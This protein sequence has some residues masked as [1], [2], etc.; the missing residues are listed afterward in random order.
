MK[1]EP[2]AIEVERKFV[3][4]GIKDLQALVQEEGGKL[5][6][7]KHFSDAYFDSDDCVLARQDVWLRRRDSAWELKV[8]VGDAEHRS[9]G[10]RSVFREIE[11]AEAVARALLTLHANGYLPHREIGPALEN[12]DLNLEQLLAEMRLKP[13]AEFQT[14]RSRLRLGRCGIDVDTASFG[15]AVL[16]LEIMCQDP[17]EVPEAEAE[18]ERVAQRLGLQPLGAYGGKL[19][20]YIRK[21][22]PNVLAHL[23]DARILKP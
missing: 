11:G 19:E 21:Y 15:H 3:V 12:H 2:R 7:E 5:L 14:M 20:T 1:V 16:E 9:G 10:E 4:S 8:P 23:V 6:G 17:E 13:F 22:C 18:I